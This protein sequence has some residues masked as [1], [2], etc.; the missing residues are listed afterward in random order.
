[1]EVSLLA[2]LHLQSPT[3]CS[4][5]VKVLLTGVR[6]ILTKIFHYLS[7]AASLMRA[8]LIKVELS[9]ASRFL[10]PHSQ[11]A[12]SMDAALLRMVEPSSSFKERNKHSHTA[13]LMTARL[14]T[15]ERWPYLQQLHLHSP[16]EVSSSPAQTKRHEA[17]ITY[18]MTQI[19]LALLI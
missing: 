17:G 4:V 10:N 11:T 9:G 14:S 19:I 5:H 16:S 7:P 3:A 8:V 18:T 1:M 15:E 2:Q 13:R 6:F 12:H